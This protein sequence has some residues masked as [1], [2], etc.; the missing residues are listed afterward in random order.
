MNDKCH[1]ISFADVDER[2][3]GGESS[4][5]LMGLG[6]RKGGQRKS[7]QTY[8]WGEEEGKGNVPVPSL[9]RSIYLIQKKCW[10][11]ERAHLIYPVLE[12]YFRTQV[13][14]NSKSFFKAFF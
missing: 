11:Y 6:G 3:G 5:S 12:G 2:G 13:V 7:T 9:E 8:P 4:G 1:S 14:G 10:K